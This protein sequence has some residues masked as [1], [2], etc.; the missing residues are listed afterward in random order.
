MGER[1]LN[2]KAPLGGTQSKIFRFTSLLQSSAPEFACSIGKPL[3]FSVN[4][5]QYVAA[6]AES[7][8][9]SPSKVEV[10]F[11]PE[12]LGK[13]QDVLTLTS[14]TG[15]EYKCTLFGECTPPLPQGPFT[16]KPGNKEALKLKFKNV[17]NAR[18]NLC[19]QWTTRRFLS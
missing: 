16:V 19:I 12:Q 1:S 2:F 4:P 9:G 10:M 18:R 13:V 7:W 5:A 6:A 11:E 17:F 8:E 14:A 3:F 15:G